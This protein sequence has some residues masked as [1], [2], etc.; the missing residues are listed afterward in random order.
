MRPK[1]KWGKTALYADILSRLGFLL[2]KKPL[3]EKYLFLRDTVGEGCE[4]AEKAANLLFKDEDVLAIL[5]E[6]DK[7]YESK[8][9]I[10]ED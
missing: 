10:T 5:K 2:A 7:F 4:L 3:W 1:E 6:M 8:Q 9:R